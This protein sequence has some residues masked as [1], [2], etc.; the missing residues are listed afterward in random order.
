M[1]AWGNIHQAK[2]P[3]LPGVKQ[4]A[5]I[6]LF[7]ETQPQSVPFFTEIVSRVKA[8]TMVLNLKIR[9][10]LQAGFKWLHQWHFHPDSAKTSWSTVDWRL[11]L[12][13]FIAKSKVICS[14]VLRALSERDKSLISAV[15]TERGFRIGMFL[16]EKGC[17]ALWELLS[18]GL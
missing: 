4:R 13:L 8:R 9:G 2:R 3:R 18:S 6:S 17:L 1:R 5:R 10:L 16:R 15:C 11:L 7:E 12:K 14:W